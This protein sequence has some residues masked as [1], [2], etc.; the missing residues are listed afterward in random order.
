[1][2]H[3]LISLECIIFF[4]ILAGNVFSSKQSSHINEHCVS[5][6]TV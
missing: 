2:L 4:L 1:M 5:V 3:E 6:Q